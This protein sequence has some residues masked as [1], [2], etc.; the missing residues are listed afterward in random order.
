MQMDYELRFGYGTTSMK[1]EFELVKE[2]GDWYIKDMND[3]QED[4]L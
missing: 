1:V 2:K 3:V 4:S